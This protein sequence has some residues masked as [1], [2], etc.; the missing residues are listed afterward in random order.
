VALGRI[1]LH[2]LRMQDVLHIGA[3]TLLGSYIRLRLVGVGVQEPA[4]RTLDAVEVELHSFASATLF[5][6]VVREDDCRL[7]V[8]FFVPFG[9]HILFARV[10][11]GPVPSPFLC[12]F[13]ASPVLVPASLFPSASKAL[14]LFPSPFPV[15]P[16]QHSHM[17]CAFLHT[18]AC[19]MS[20]L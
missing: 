3:L 5:A 20:S 10:R 16:S 15:Y 13:P 2:Y 14:S 12:L 17:D 7:V 8:S 4:V 1:W 9:G 6:L 11:L 18:Q 19:R